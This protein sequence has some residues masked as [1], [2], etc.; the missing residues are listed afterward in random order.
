MSQCE[1]LGVQHQ[2]RRQRQRFGMRVERVAQDRVSERRQ[3]N[4]DLMRAAGPWANFEAA[5]LANTRTVQFSR[6]ALDQFPGRNRG[7]AVK[8]VDL[9]SR[10]TLEVLAQR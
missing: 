10:R 7:P 2:S 5:L 1:P 4:A 9:V 8:R 6:K 3:V